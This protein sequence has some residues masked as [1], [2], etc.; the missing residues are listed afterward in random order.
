MGW[1]ISTT[2]AVRV[3]STVFTRSLNLVISFKTEKVGSAHLGHIIT[4]VMLRFTN[5]SFMGD[6]PWANISG[7]SLN[8]L[9]NPL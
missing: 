4:L 2:S 3:A 9:Q 6:R 1:Y 7:S 8:A 5:I